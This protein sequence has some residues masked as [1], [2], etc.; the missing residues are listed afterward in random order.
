MGFAIVLKIPFS[1]TNHGGQAKVQ[2]MTQTPE[3]W[4][5][6]ADSG[7]LGGRAHVRREIQSYEHIGKKVTIR[8]SCMSLPEA[9]HRR[10]WRGP[11]R[12][13]DRRDDESICKT[14]SND[15]YSKK[16]KSLI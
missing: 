6:M 5:G 3:I 14:N 13:Q 1:S 15:M 11:V 4:R 16:L 10:L 2:G 8:I 9:F 12:G 7:L